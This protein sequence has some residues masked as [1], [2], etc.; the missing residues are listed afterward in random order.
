MRRCWPK[1]CACGQGRKVE[2]A[3]PQRGEKRELVDHAAQNGREALGRKLSDSAS[4]SK[5][6]DALGAAF[7]VGKPIRRVEVYDNSHIMGANAVG[8]M[9]VAGEAGFLKTH[10]RTFNIKNTELTPGDDF[11]MMREVLTRRFARLLKESPRADLPPEA[12]AEEEEAGFPA[13]PD[14][15]LIDGGRGQFD[16]ARSVRQAIGDQRRRHRLDCQGP[17]PR[18]G[19]RAV[20]SLKDGS[21]SALPRATRRCTS[22]SGC[23]TRRTVFAIGAHRAKRKK[24]FTKSPLEEISG[25]GPARKRALLQ[26]FGTAKAIARASL[27]DLEKVPGVNAA[28]AKVVY[29]FFQK[30]A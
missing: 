19:P 20:F 18:C 5:L 16:V 17:R 24:E 1:R 26:A 2:V 22:S 25:I 27:G 9:V 21:P 13:W 11:G 4:Q 23:A 29:D 12:L 6:L 3:V 15:V 28:T 10:Y 7:G 14:L 8:A 30:G